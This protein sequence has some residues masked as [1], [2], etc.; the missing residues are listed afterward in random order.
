MLPFLSLLV[1]VHI[2]P[3]ADKIEYRQPQLAA[4]ADLVAVAFGADKTIY[5]SASHD[6][7]RTFSSPVKVAEAPMLLSL[8]RHRG[9]RIAITPA[10]IVISA[11]VGTKTPP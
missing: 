11:V 3:G 6:R 9:P 1:A 7:G 2:T 8:G 5:F 10:A 4:T